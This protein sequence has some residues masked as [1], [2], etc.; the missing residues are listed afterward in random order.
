MPYW[1]HLANLIAWTS[2]TDY[3]FNNMNDVYP[4]DQ[5]CHTNSPHAIW[6]EESAGLLFEFAILCDYINSL[7]LKSNKQ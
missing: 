7:I 2:Q 3:D 1:N 6:H 5:F 4:G